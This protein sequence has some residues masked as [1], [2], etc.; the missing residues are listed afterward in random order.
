MDEEATAEIS[1]RV[2]RH[3]LLR[4]N[5][6][7]S[8]RISGASQSVEDWLSAQ[9]TSYERLKELALKAIFYSI[10][11]IVFA[12]AI[13]ILS[14]LLYSIFYFFYV[15]TALHRFPLHFNYGCAE[16]LETGPIAAV[17]LTEDSSQL[18]ARN[19][20][21]DV[22]FNAVLPESG[23]NFESGMFMV[24]LALA[25]SRTA[26]TEAA[27]CSAYVDCHRSY[28]Q[29]HDIQSLHDMQSPYESTTTIS[30]STVL[31]Y[32]SWLHHAMRTFVFSVPLILGVVDESQTVELPLFDNVFDNAT[33][34]YTWAAVSISKTSVQLYTSELRFH[35]HFTGATYLM[36]DWFY[37]SF[38]VGVF[39]TGFV[40]MLSVLGGA[41]VYTIFWTE[42][43]VTDS[44]PRYAPTASHV[45]SASVPPSAAEMRAAAARDQMLH[46]VPASDI[47]TFRPPVPDGGE[48][49]SP[50]GVRRS[51]SDDIDSDSTGGARAQ[52]SDQREGAID[53]ADSSGTRSVHAAGYGVRLRRTSTQGS[54]RGDFI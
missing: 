50:P 42:E 30:R 5:A 48:R 1:R 20:G 52:E 51:T 33:Q 41:Y 49:N 10:I 31:K 4:R 9:W 36:H 47:V 7:F 21:Y 2:L 34:P 18:L 14:V 19:Q 54:T 27:R 28:G 32:R 6:P 13:S 45:A 3:L 22:Y 39:S 37:S 44:A 40:L 15:P 46:Y 11:L 38:L 24:T 23:K 29:K 8:D 43:S 17:R 26:A 16:T 53:R 12:W 35:A 25:S